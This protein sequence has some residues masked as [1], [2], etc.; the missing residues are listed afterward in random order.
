MVLAVFLIF[1]EIEA[2]HR[3]ILIQI[4]IMRPVDETPTAH[5]FAAARTRKLQK[6]GR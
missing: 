1:V 4:V 5:I 6:L 3:T 2:A